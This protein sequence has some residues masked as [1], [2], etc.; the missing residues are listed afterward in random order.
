MTEQTTFA[1]S[2][3]EVLVLRLPTGE[4]LIGLATDDGH[5]YTVKQPLAIGIDHEKQRLVFVPFMPYTTAKDE[6][7]LSKHHVV[8]TVKPVESIKNDYL[9]ATGNGP[10]IIAPTRELIRPVK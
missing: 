1:G 10:R 4:E 7:E 6:I 3:P 8:I 9:E 5:T 2:E